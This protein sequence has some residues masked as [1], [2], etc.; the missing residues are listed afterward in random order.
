MIDTGRHGFMA[1]FLLIPN[2]PD[3]VL[4][5]LLSVLLWATLVLYGGA[6]LWWLI[7]VFILSY[8]WQDTNQTEVGLD[9]IQVRVLTIA[10]EE[11]VQR[12]VSSIPDEITDTLVIAEE[13]ID[14]A[15][16]DVH[17]VPDDFECAAQRKGR[18]IEWARQQ[19]PCEKEYVLYL[20]EDTLLSGFSGLPAADIIQLSEHPLRTHSRLTYV[21]EIFRIGFQ[22]EQRAFH[23]VAY[24]AYAW[25]GAV[26]VRHEL[27]EQITWNVP[28][29]TEDTTFI[30]RAAARTNIDY[31]LATVKARNQA[32]PTLK[33]LIKQR[34]RW[35]SGTIQDRNLLPR[36][37]QPVIFTRIV[38]WALSPVIPL[39]GIIAFVFP[40]AIPSSSVY[41]LLSAL[42]FGIV[43]LYMIFGLVEYR[44]YPEVWW[45]YIVVTP[46]AVLVH[47]LGALWGIMQPVDDFE[48]TQKTAA[49]DTGTLEER[50][51]ELTEDESEYDTKAETEPDEN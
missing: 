36:R 44:K 6:S 30:W 39:F 19:I 32:P 42:L 48:V 9:N 16:A 26:A 27:E 31:R 49:I 20:D 8:G 24:P 43:F 50:N 22:F 33:S 10:A 46:L 34:R 17:V 5:Q 45:A 13:D 29:I 11:T 21:C 1:L 23:Q 28:S 47:S 18:A 12:T 40:E 3:A 25:G 2:V 15:G 4:A 41:L 7:Q 35:V 14:I 51:P 38:T 37:Y